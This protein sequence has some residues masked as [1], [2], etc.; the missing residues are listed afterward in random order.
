MR[1]NESN[2]FELKTVTSIQID[3]QLNLHTGEGDVRNV[4]SFVDTCGRV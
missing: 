4:S 1:I 3:K 2:V